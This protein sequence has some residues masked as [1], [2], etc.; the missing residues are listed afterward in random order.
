MEKLEKQKCLNRSNPDAGLVKKFCLT[1]DAGR[2]LLELLLV[3][4]IVLIVAGIGIPIL[5]GALQTVRGLMGLVRQV[6]V[7]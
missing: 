6:V 5:W 7:H 4:G 1:K 2:S 3:L